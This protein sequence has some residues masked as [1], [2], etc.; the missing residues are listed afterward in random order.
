MQQ[1][2]L[3][4]Q[5]RPL[6]FLA[7]VV[8]VPRNVGG[9]LGCQSDPSLYFI[10]DHNIKCAPVNSLQESNPSFQTVVK[11]IA[12]GAGIDI[13]VR[14]RMIYWSDTTAWTINR[15]NL[16]SGEVKVIVRQNVGEVYSLA[17]EWESGLI[18]WTDFIYER[19]EVAKLDGSSRKTLVT[20][21]ARSPV[22]I[23][24]DPGS[25]Y[26]VWVEHDYATRKIMRADLTGENPLELQKLFHGLPFYVII[27]HSDNRV[28]WTDIRL[29]FTFIGS[30]GING[31]GFKA[32][33]YVHPGYFPFDLAISQNTFYWADQNL[34]G[35]SWFNLQ[36]SSSRVV[37]RQ[38]LSPYDL[39]GVTISDSSTQ[40]IAIQENPCVVNNGNCS[41]LC[42]LTPGRARK[43]ACP[44]GVKLKNDGMTCENETAAATVPPPL[45][46]IQVRLRP[47]SASAEGRGRVEI[48]YNGVW[49]TVCDDYWGL[50]EAHVIC[51]MLNYSGAEFAPRN[52]F[53]GR[54]QSTMPIHLDNIKCRGDESTIAAC[55][56][57][58]WGQNDCYHSEDAGVICWTD[59]AP[60]VQEPTLAPGP[61]PELKVQLQGGDSHYKGRVEIYLNGTWG[62]VCDDSWGIEEANVICRMLN[63]TEGAVS[64]QCCG[65][66]NGYGVSEK[67][68]LDDVH[69]V[70]NE[71]SIAECRHGGWGKHNCRHS[72]DVGVVCKHAPL[73]TPDQM[74]RLADGGRESEGRV[75]V[76]HNGEWGTVC[77]DHWDIDDGD[78][79]CKMLNYSRA[80]RAPKQAFF[81]QGN[82][83]IWLGNVKCRG[84]ETGLLQCGHQGWNVDHCD[85]HED[86]SV[87]CETEAPYLES[88]S[89]ILA[90]GF[91]R[92]LLYHVPLDNHLPEKGIPL[93]IKTNKPL[94]VTY[95]TKDNMAYWTERS[96]SILRAYLNGNS[97]ETL[98]TGLTRPTAIEID[99]V[100]HNLYVADQNGVT[101]SKLDGSY[102]TLLINLTSC[103]GIALDTVSGYIYFTVTGVSPRILRADMDGKNLLVL[104]NVSSLRGT[105]LDIALDKVNN[106]L[107]YS[108]E[109]N[110]LVKYI[111]LTSRM[112]HAVLYSNP[113]RPVGLTL[114]N[115]TLYWTGEGTVES[116]SGGIYKVQ[117]DT[118]NGGI[119]REVV[120]LLSYPKGIY[121]HDI[122]M[123]IP[124][125]DD[126]HPCA[127]NN[128]SCS[129]LCLINPTG[130]SCLCVGAGSCQ[131]SVSSLVLATSSMNTVTTT[132]FSSTTH[133]TAKST[134]IHTSV[135]VSPS[136]SSPISSSSTLSQ[137]ASFSS[138]MTYRLVTKL[139]ASSTVN[140]P[141]SP[142]AP[143]A[144]HVSLKPSQAPSD[145]CASQNPCED[146]GSCQADVVEGY[147]C[148]CLDYFF[149]QHCSIDISGGVV[150]LLINIQGNEF[151]K[152]ALKQVILQILNRQCEDPESEQ[153]PITPSG[154]ARRR[155]AIA[156]TTF[157]P[158]EV[159]VKDPK[160]IDE[161]LQVELAVVKLRL[162]GSAFVVSSANLS[163]IIQ[164][165]AAE[166]GQRL[167]G[168]LLSATP[169]FPV[170]TTHATQSTMS[171]DK[172]MTVTQG[173]PKVSTTIPGTTTGQVPARPGSA[174]ANKGGDDGGVIGGVV[175]AALVIIILVIALAVWYFR[176]K[177]PG[178]PFSYK[179]NHDGPE[180]RVAAFENPGYDNAIGF[181][182]HGENLYDDLPPPVVLSPYEDFNDYGAVS[183]PIYSEFGADRE[184]SVRKSNFG[185]SLFSSNGKDT[186]I[187]ANDA[188]K[189]NESIA[190]NKISLGDTS[191]VKKNPDSK[192][193]GTNQGYEKKGQT[194][195]V[196][197]DSNEINKASEL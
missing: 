155:R 173:P 34:H 186:E 119:V 36:S 35:V 168:K 109:G 71:N 46:A 3:Y 190:G 193:T 103:H 65:F 172:H 163:K 32:E 28:Y 191:W 29:S 21:N 94:A 26:M 153:C 177:I 126:S 12:E 142:V 116:F 62:T 13:D 48:L 122:R 158:E 73:S 151:N 134:K 125:V 97:R 27:N 161:K 114:F 143:T 24:V 23:S 4:K 18:Y 181:A 174:S 60:P 61:H 197:E 81:G 164:A 102:Q 149:G 148:V 72:E 76:F 85:H 30:I 156:K 175:V 135:L 77:D 87:I 170:P 105:T 137:H 68:W 17:V 92:D 5:L 9:T 55:R 182:T 194:V 121:A 101:V 14:N 108:D 128:G 19:I 37:N 110:N 179:R 152:T 20:Q 15:M 165:S 39:I 90:C 187:G 162:G 111:N 139:T 123:K 180:P 63:F 8:L 47:L 113:R 150:V 86:A 120:D 83:K 192:E 107:Y 56:H 79:V 58:G 147:K 67:I 117:T 75:E 69:C 93:A 169:K 112:H 1:Q 146:R 45:P 154:G 99:Y 167:G 59:S 118:L 41:D 70:G 196:L 89:F 124:P 54:G 6:V 43:C 159:I 178:L 160:Q 38:N 144:T 88:K 183:N 80:L 33:K 91:G 176:V 132:S 11:N 141:P 16:T 188:K 106:R 140:F 84:N 53:F 66:Y 49:G 104:T 7:L 145:I 100:S 78:V 115:G 51:R 184:G 195:L 64:T 96:G 31:K 25:G 157:S 22:G 185:T 166:I 129:H 40:P 98:L 44:E 171:G 50:D 57:N 136:T 127:R 42:L 189:S 138:S 95:N 10:D 74:V 2:T 130:H 52:A 131:T 133:V 82:G